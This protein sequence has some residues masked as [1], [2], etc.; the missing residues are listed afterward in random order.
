MCSFVAFSIK[1]PWWVITPYIGTI[2]ISGLSAIYFRSPFF[3]SLCAA[4]LLSPLSG[5]A[6]YAIS[7]ALVIRELR[8]WSGII[9]FPAFF[10]GYIGAFISCLW[11][12]RINLFKNRR[13]MPDVFL[14]LI[15]QRKL[16]LPPCPI[17]RQARND[18]V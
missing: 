18:G 1:H 12:L 7:A 13:E 8:E 17:S 11:F 5:F 16:L 14:R 10:I 6:C 9:I 2:G 4:L 3:V 15:L